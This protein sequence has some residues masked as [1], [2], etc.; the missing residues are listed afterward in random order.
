MSTTFP[1]PSLVSISLLRLVSYQ[2]VPPMVVES[3][4]T[5]SWVLVPLMAM[6]PQKAFPDPA[7]YTK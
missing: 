5:I 4:K 1:R 3:C 6:L 7:A 2:V